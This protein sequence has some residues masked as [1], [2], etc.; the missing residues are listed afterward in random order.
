MRFRLLLVGVLVLFLLPSPQ[1]QAESSSSFE[2]DFTLQWSHDFG[3]AYITTAPLFAGERLFVRTSASWGG[4]S[5]PTVASFTLEG[6]LVWSESNA[7]STHHDMAPL[8][9][10]MAG[11][12]SCGAWPE[13]MIVGWSDGTVEARSP[14]DGSLLWAYE[15]EQVTWGV[16]GMMALDEDQIIVPTR[17]GLVSL[18]ASDG[19]MTMEAT[20]GL[21]WR[22]GVTVGAEEYFLGD[23]SGVLWSVATNGT[24]RSVDLGDGKIRHAPILTSAGLLV[25]LQGQ[26]SSTMYVL[27]LVNLSTIQTLPIGP[28]PGIPTAAGAFVLAFDSEAIRSLSCSLIC[29]EVDRVPFLSNGEIGLAHDGQYMLPYNGN[30]QGWGL[31]NITEYG[32]LQVQMA[33]TGADGYATA[34]PGFTSSVT[35]GEMLAF[36]SDGGVVYVHATTTKAVEP[37]LE[38]NVETFDWVSQGIVFL[39]YLALGG[40]GVQLLRGNWASMLKF[41]SVYML[42]IGLVVIDQVA[43][44]WSQTLDE[45]DTQ[46][47]NDEWD[48]SWNE[49]WRGT[50]I[51][52]ITIGGEVHAAGGFEGYTNAL[53]LTLAACEE[54]GVE[55]E[56]ESTRIGTYVL[57]FDGETG[58]GWEYT[59]DGRLATL[60]SDYST[61][62]SSTRVEWSPVETR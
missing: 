6:E 61:I 18:C 46:S 26:Q 1:V 19:S 40:A 62:D 2:E 39:L 23:E 24:T 50:Q 34:A 36:G 59:L 52:S 3:D 16:T 31:V 53:D 49:S 56:T 60:A 14:S 5:V 57:S 30:E 45:L 20:T 58:E 29:E 38:Q 27:D 15:T 17:T 37:A 22:N 4:S 43:I 11:N 13:M 54:L 47:E 48:P 35:H 33:T 7:H 21:G 42:L 32:R 9:H 51:V 10:L 8:L 44:Q 55:I 25:Q 12:G 41:L 28:S